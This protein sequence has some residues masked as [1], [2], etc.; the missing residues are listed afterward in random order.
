[1]LSAEKKAEV[2]KVVETYHQLVKQLE[3]REKLQEMLV[4]TIGENPPNGLHKQ[5]QPDKQHEKQKQTEKNILKSEIQRGEVRE[6]ATDL[7]KVQKPI[8]I[9]NAES[10]MTMQNRKCENDKEKQLEIEQEKGQHEKDLAEKAEKD[11]AEKAEALIE[12]E[13]ESR[14]LKLKLL[15][16]LLSSDVENSEKYCSQIEELLGRFNEEFHGNSIPFEIRKEFMAG[17]GRF[18]G[19]D[20]Y[21]KVEDA[22]ME[23]QSILKFISK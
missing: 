18:E 14:I 10:K 11:L 23:L 13:I 16:K 22:L 20:T 21:Q 17:V 12:A 4:K 6:V 5:Q 1:M 7:R 9:K 19:D 2:K 15:Y 8:M 3:Q